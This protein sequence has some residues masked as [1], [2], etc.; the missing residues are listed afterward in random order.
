MQLSEAI[1]FIQCDVLDQAPVSKW[2]DLGCG[3]G[4]FSTALAHYLPEGSTV[5]AV[6]QQPATRIAGHGVEILEL[7]FV[8]D[9]FPFGRVDGVLMANSLHYVKDKP[10]L[11]QKIKNHTS[12]LIIIE[13]DIEKPVP[14]WVPF[15]LSFRQLST[16]FP[17]NQIKKLNERP[18]AYGRGNMYAALIY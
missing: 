13:Y 6:D 4:L 9:P 14:T 8:A 10:G 1:Q 5:Y 3:S 17:D 2:A 7:D 12:T 11:I 16:F 15:P 18:S